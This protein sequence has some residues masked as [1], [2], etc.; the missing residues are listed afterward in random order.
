MT[1]ASKLIESIQ[2]LIDEHGD[3]YICVSDIKNPVYDAI[4]SV[5]CDIGTDGIKII[6]INI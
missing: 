5:G 6:T 2:A 3:Q 1:L 4:L